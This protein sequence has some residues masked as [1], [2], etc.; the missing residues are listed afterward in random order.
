MSGF[1]K[2]QK[3]K[4]I[5]NMKK[6]IYS[7]LLVPIAIGISSSLSFA[8]NVMTPELLWQLGRVSGEC[9]T[10][11]GKNVIYG[12]RYYDMQANKGSGN[13]YSVPVAGGEPKQI[14][15]D[16]GSESN[17]QF[18][19]DGHL[20]YILKGN[21]Y[22]TY[23]NF[24]SPAKM[25]NDSE[26][27]DNVKFSPDGKWVL[28]TKSVKLD[29]TTAD[30]YP[31]LPKAK[32]R[33][34][35]NLMYRHWDMW[36]DG[37]YSHVFIAPRTVVAMGIESGIP[38]Y[39][40]KMDKTV[41]IMKGEPYFCPTQ[42]EGGA[43][44]VAWSPDSKT[45]VY[46]TKKKKGTAYTL[47]TN[48]DLYFYDVATGAT[49][50]FTEDNKGYDTQPV[51]SPD[52]SKLAWLSMERDGYEADKNRIMVYDFK[53]KQKFELTKDW[54]ESASSLRWNKDGN[55]LFF[56]ENC[57]GTDQLFEISIP[58]DLNKISSKDFR[59]VTSGMFDVT[60]MLGIDGNNMYVTRTDMNHAAEI[61]RI[62]IKTGEFTQLTFTNKAAYDKIQMGKIEERWI[63]T[64]DYKKELVWVIYPPGFDSTKKY[65]TLLYCQGGPQSSLSQF[66]SFRWNFQL[67][68]ANGYIIVAP[69]RRG[70]PGF[71][72][73]WN[74]EISRDWGGQC[75]KDYLSAIDSISKLSF[76]DKD[77]RGAI[78]ASFGGYSIYFLEGNSGKRF[79]TFISHDGVFDLESMYGTTDEM[80]FNN[81]EFGGSYWQSPAPVDYTKFNPK[82][83]V[84]NWNT[85]ILVIHG[86]EDY[87]VPVEQ[88]MEAFQA[89][90]LK[91][92]KSRFLYFENEG[93][94]VLKPQDGLLWQHEFYRWLK[95]TL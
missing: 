54:E 15:N 18:S 80:W 16:G 94:W 83:F 43:E 51:F 24:S 45:I 60:A 68:A 6:L 63:K 92:I 38:G 66:Y 11:D 57:F 28:F 91:G 90:Q 75:M 86:Q 14:T 65:P 76:V 29:K 27:I 26:G 32:A 44:D 82:N 20:E 8:Q 42:P 84:A 2:K 62:N 5:N 7:L 72:T 95:E 22:D 33:I 77:R 74:Q 79:K 89:A 48:T 3:N 36:E 23:G 56:I 13:L 40:I 69:C 93:H 49:T 73:A 31:N 9:L 61:F 71:G 46:V 10:P 30:D 1:I 87:R 37:T 59:Q 21:L 50:D 67:M 41:D 17:V 55:K 35:D 88:G 12:V 58:K 47:S 70:M 64:T 81:W 85:P 34:M 19:P 78:G 25:T 4:K 52:G 53:L 39:G